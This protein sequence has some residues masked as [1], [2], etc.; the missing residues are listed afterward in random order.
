MMIIEI[1]FQI[2]KFNKK[3][4]AI[5]NRIRI[6]DNLMEKRCLKITI[7]FFFV[8]RFTFFFQIKQEIR[9]KMKK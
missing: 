2:I 4:I 7:L 1:C 6:I 5:L 3:L 8:L 9:E